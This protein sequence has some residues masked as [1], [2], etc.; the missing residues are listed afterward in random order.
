MSEITKTSKICKICNI[1][2]DLSEFYFHRGECKACHNQKR[3]VDKTLLGSKTCIKCNEEKDIKRF[4]PFRNVCY[5]C[6]NEKRKRYM[7]EYYEQNKKEWKEKER[8]R[9]EKKLRLQD[10]E[11]KSK[12]CKECSEVKSVKEFRLNRNL[13]K[14]CEKKWNREWILNKKQND[15]IFKFILICRNRIIQ[16]IKKEN[17]TQSTIKY[18]GED[19]DIIK[20]WFEFCFSYEFTWN[21]HGS[22]W[23]IDH[24]IPVSRFNLQTEDNVITCFNWKNL[25]PLLAKENLTKSNNIVLTQIQEHIEKLREF[26]SKYYMDKKDEVETYITNIFLPY[27]T[28]DQ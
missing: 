19:V 12:E 25:S 4:R 2:K 8:L 23:H 28:N 16:E 10:K 22:V 17:K 6:S 24:V 7:K 3:R 9:N 21:N 11:E 27:L 26:T 18:L 20:K 14:E 13:C 5:D 1:D 15:P